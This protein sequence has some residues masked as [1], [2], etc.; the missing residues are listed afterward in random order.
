[1]GVQSGGGSGRETS[2]WGRPSKDHEPEVNP[3]PALRGRARAESP[4]S[5][6]QCWTIRIRSHIRSGGNVVEPGRL[7]R[8]GSRPATR[9]DRYQGVVEM[10]DDVALDFPAQCAAQFLGR[11]S[12]SRRP[13]PEDLANV[14]GGHQRQAGP[15]VG[16]LL[17]EMNQIPRPR[18]PAVI[19]RSCL[20]QGRT[21]PVA[22]GLG[23]VRL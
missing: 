2:V 8:H 15:R 22:A 13:G 4:G 21:L 16:I 11:D 7:L 18:P 10:E 9:K 23:R 1:M 20:R 12:V 19:S 17:Q 14:P 3:V 5:R 6:D